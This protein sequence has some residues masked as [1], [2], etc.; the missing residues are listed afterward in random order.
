[1]LFNQP[2]T[3]TPQM[4]GFVTFHFNY[5]NNLNLFLIVL[6]F[7]QLAGQ[8][9]HCECLTGNCNSISSDDSAQHFF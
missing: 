6:R 7:V 2:Q 4:W 9:K 1:M 5:L 3:A 8:N